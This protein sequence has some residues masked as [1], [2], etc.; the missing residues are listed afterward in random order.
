M[1]FQ[2]EG[3]FLAYSERM[4]EKFNEK[5][6]IVGRWTDE[7]LDAALAD[8]GMPT[9]ATLPAEPTGPY[10]ET[11]VQ[12]TD[13]RIWQRVNAAHLLGHVI[14]HNGARC[15]ACETWGKDA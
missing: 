10:V 5:Y 8:N 2:S 11:C 13:G 6:C 3:E 7:Q 9:L 1:Q 15:G 12:G 4:A 14:L